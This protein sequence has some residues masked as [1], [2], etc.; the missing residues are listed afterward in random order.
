MNSTLGCCISHMEIVGACP[1]F[2]SYLQ[3]E[4]A[5]VQMHPNWPSLISPLSLTEALYLVLYELS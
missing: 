5:V 4:G 1:Y 3:L 2:C